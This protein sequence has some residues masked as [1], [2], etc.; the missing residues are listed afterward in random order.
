MGS[1]G[2]MI[3]DGFDHYEV[4]K[5]MMAGLL[6]PAD[7]DWPLLDLGYL[8]VRRQEAL[9]STKGRTPRNTEREQSCWLRLHCSSSGNRINRWPACL[10]VVMASVPPLA[11]QPSLSSLPHPYSFCL[12]K[13]II[14]LELEKRVS[15][16]YLFLELCS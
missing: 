10:K 2:S 5:P 16:F 13:S 7:L 9:P 11:W 8:L 12:E 4:P 6:F 14:F 3:M 1:L 15:D